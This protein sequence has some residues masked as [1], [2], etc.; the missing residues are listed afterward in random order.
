MGMDFLD[1]AN[2]VTVP[3]ISTLFIMDNGEAHAIPMRRKVEKES[4]LPVLRFTENKEVDD[5]STI[6][7]NEGSEG[8]MPLTLPRK[9]TQ[10]RKRARTRMG[11]KCAKDRCAESLAMTHQRNQV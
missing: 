2:A 4:V 6:K 11:S 8:V 3:H 5:L 7:S 9:T 1:K 10:R